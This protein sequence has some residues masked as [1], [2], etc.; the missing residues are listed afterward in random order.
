MIDFISMRKFGD[1]LKQKDRDDYLIFILAVIFFA[2]RILMLVVGFEFDMG[3]LNTAWQNVDTWLLRN[4]LFRSIWYLHSQPPFFNLFIGVVLKLFPVYFAGVFQVIFHLLGFVLALCLYFI[5]RNLSSNRLLSFVV[6]LFFVLSPSVILFENLFFYD[7]PVMVVLVVIAFFFQKF[8]QTNKTAYLFAFFSTAAFL[9][10]T[11]RVFHLVWFLAVAGILL[12]FYRREWKRI[13]LVFLLPLILIVFWY[14]KNFYYFGNFDASS[15]SGMGF[16]KTAGYVLNKAEKQK[17]FDEGV[18]SAHIFYVGDPFQIP[19]STSATPAFSEKILAVPV[20]GSYMKKDGGINYN[21]FAYI[22]LSRQVMGDFI[23]I[24]KH[25]PSAYMKGV[26]ATGIIFFSPASNY[27]AA[28]ENNNTIYLN[29]QLVKKWDVFFDRI[30]YGQPLSWGGKI[31]QNYL[32]RSLNIKETYAWRLLSPGLFLI[33]M[34]L[35]SIFYG[36]KIIFQKNAILKYGSAVYLTVIFLVVNILYVSA[37]GILAEAGENQ[38]HRF[39]VEPFV[40]VMFAFFI[41]NNLF[42]RL[43]N[44]F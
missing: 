12:Y 15:W 5:V 6:S 7:F 21:H 18:V 36:F 40:W 30:V 25:H 35:I 44:R 24:L 1:L 31:L 43:S 22:G 3:F 32:T 9:V 26:I 33:V 42:K 41:Q 13:V 20:V 28:S 38:R 17:L 29:Y 10:L 16:F 37:V 39:A 23:S 14:G 8:V 2:S 4:D 11:R 34:H 27:F 19:V